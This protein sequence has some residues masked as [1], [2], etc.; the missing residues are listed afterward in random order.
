[1]KDIQAVVFDLYGTLIYLANETKPYARLFANMGLQ[2]PEE[3]KQA[4]TIALTEDFSNLSNLVK[5][6]KPDS[7]V[8]LIPYEREIEEEVASAETYPETRSV[9]DDLRKINIKLGLVSNLAS[10]YKKPFFV[11]RLDQYF[12]EVIFSCDI[13]LRKPETKIYQK[14]I[15]ML[16]I[17]PAQ[18]LMT[19]DKVSADVDGPKSICMNAV[20]LD[21]TNTS[22]NSISTLDKIFSVF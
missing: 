21:R 5:R 18:T 17:N 9:L 4:R 7:K 3:L 19:G 13:G 2:T 16:K 8:D 6:I 12:D 20:H 11:L 22:S 1:M 10:P 14:I 15:E